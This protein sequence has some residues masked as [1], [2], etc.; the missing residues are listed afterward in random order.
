M[1]LWRTHLWEHSLF[2]NVVCPKHMYLIG[3]SDDAK[4]CIIFCIYASHIIMTNYGR[5]L[6]RKC[7]ILAELEWHAIDFVYTY[8]DKTT[9]VSTV[10]K[11]CELLRI[12]ARNFC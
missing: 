10:I 12:I 9:P 5:V 1:A 4:V 7:E 3:Q 8:P 11:T 2:H 6:V